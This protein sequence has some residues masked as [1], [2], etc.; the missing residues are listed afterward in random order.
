MAARKRSTPTE[1]EFAP[2]P[3]ASIPRDRATLA[4]IGAGTLEVL[5]D[6]EHKKA[7]A[8]LETKRAIEAASK[9]Q[10]RARR[11]I[12]PVKSRLCNVTLNL[13]AIH[14]LCNS[15]MELC[16]AG[17]AESILLLIR[18]SARSSARALDACSQRLGDTAMGCF[19]DDLES[20]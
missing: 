18:E 1:A 14:D 7:Q 9:R 12:G 3:T 15:A 19:A 17:E 4:R 16:G 5:A 13:I 6:A 10:E 2:I 8:A 20:H 11:G